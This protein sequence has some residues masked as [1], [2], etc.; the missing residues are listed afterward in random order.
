MVDYFKIHF[1]N[2]LGETG[3]PQKA[4]GRT[5]DKFYRHTKLLACSS[6]VTKV[7]QVGECSSIK[8]KMCM[9]KKV[10]PA[11]EPQFFARHKRTHDIIR[12]VLQI[13]GFVIE[14]HAQWEL[15]NDLN[16][17]F[18]CHSSFCVHSDCARTW[19][20]CAT[21][22]GFSFRALDFEA[23]SRVL[24]SRQPTCRRLTQCT[25]GTDY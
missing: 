14:T 9:Q 19:S 15:L 4:W 6:A 13:S 5:A 11:R 10:I 12:C 18:L 2:L 7:N 24:G 1:K 20:S 16:T 22:S 25:M 8:Y 17:H 21:H 3:K 23:V